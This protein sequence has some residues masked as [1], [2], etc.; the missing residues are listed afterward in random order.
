MQHSENRLVDAKV[1]C[2]TCL[3]DLL[4]G[5]S[6]LRP[7][8]A[9]IG[10]LMAVDPLPRLAGAYWTCGAFFESQ[11]LCGAYWVYG[12]YVACG[13]Y[14]AYAGLRGAIRGLSTRAWLVWVMGLVAFR[15]FRE[16]VRLQ[17]QQG[18]PSNE[19]SGRLNKENPNESTYRTKL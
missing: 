16:L 18:S 9:E 6:R 5:H 19:R 2:N 12:A 13:V 15:S 10:G 17:R 4:Q 1:F 8:R 11:G 14:R 7:R 3:L